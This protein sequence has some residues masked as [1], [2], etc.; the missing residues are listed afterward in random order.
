MK[1]LQVV[2][3]GREAHIIGSALVGSSGRQLL[4]LSDGPDSGDC[5]LQLLVLALLHFV[6][7]TQL[8]L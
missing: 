2:H 1:L 6:L 8:E 3:K 4:V 7:S 5:T